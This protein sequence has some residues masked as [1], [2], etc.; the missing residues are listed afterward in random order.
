M[1]WVNRRNEC[2]AAV[3]MKTL[4]S[5]A[6]EAVDTRHSQTARLVDDPPTFHHD[7]TKF[8]V[9]RGDNTVR[10]EAINAR[11]IR[12]SHK[13][14]QPHSFDIS[15]GLARDQQ[16]VMTTMDGEQEPWQILYRAL[17]SLFFP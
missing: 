11:T 14:D 8:W 16:C 13:G 5:E 3:F 2:N 4:F 6:K 17:D 1:N 12:V 10:F 7:G 15:V 9:T